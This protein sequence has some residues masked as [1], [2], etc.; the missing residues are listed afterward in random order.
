MSAVLYKKHGAIGHI[1]LNRPEKLNAINRE[2]LDRLTSALS[3]AQ[4]DSNIRAVVLS[5]AGRAFSS[6]FDLDMGAPADGESKSD[7]L[8]RELQHDFDTIMRFHD[9]PKPIVVAVHGYCL[10]SSMEIAALCDITLA[11]TDCRFGAPEVRFGSGM[12]C[13]ILP[14]I[15]GQKHA[16]E[17]LLVGKKGA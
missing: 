8:R 9:F 5:G 14:W 4:E 3:A 17:M 15:V 12:V 7:F 16:R 10:G 2:M 6:G 1:E 13:L 11:A